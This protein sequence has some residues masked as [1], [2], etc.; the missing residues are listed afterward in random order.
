M[1]DNSFDSDF[2][3]NAWHGMIESFDF[4][5]FFKRLGW[6]IQSLISIAFKT[7]WMDDDSLILDFFEMPS[8]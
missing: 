1:D 5:F 2:F 7:P 8:P 4:E 3:S 6:M